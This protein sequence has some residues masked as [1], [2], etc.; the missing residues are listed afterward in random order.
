M[1]IYITVLLNISKNTAIEK[2]ILDY[3]TFLNTSK[4]GEKTDKEW[5][6]DARKYFCKVLSD[7]IT[8]MQNLLTS[9]IETI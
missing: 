3:T 1:H 7:K 8:T 2:E 5:L 9:T 4:L 6:K